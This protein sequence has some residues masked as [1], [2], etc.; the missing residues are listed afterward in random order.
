[1]IWQAQYPVIRQS[2]SNSE[3]M[4]V[5][6]WGSGVY[7]MCVCLGGRVLCLCCVCV[8]CVCVCVFCDECVRVWGPVVGAVCVCVCVLVCVSQCKKVPDE[9]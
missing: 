4:S 1:M 5:C 9:W 8:V 2:K 7:S 6:V 3:C